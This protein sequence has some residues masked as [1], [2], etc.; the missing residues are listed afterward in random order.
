MRYSSTGS[1]RAYLEG[2]IARGKGRAA[3]RLPPARELARAAGVAESTLLK[4]VRQLRDEGVLEVSHGKGIRTVG[5]PARCGPRVPPAESSGRARWQQVA[6]A[7]YTR[8]VRGEWETIP[9][10]KELRGMLGASYP[11]LRRALDHLVRDGILETYKRTYRVA[12]PTVPS[13]ANMVVLISRGIDMQDMARAN[14]PHRDM[15]HELEYQCSRQQLKLRPVSYHYR[16][17]LLHGFEEL[18]KVVRSDWVLGYIICAEGIEHNCLNNTLR[19]LRDT[20]RPVALFTR[21]EWWD[22][23]ALVQPRLTRIYAPSLGPAPGRAVAHYLATL[24]HQRIAFVD[25][26]LANNWSRERLQGMREV[27]RLGGGAAAVTRFTP[28][29][30]VL[31]TT[32][33]GRL[34]REAERL[35]DEMVG[36]LQPSGDAQNWASHLLT[37]IPGAAGQIRV[38]IELRTAVSECLDRILDDPD[39][40]CIVGANDRMA[41][42]CLEG[43][44]ERGIDVPGRLSVAGFDNSMEAF[45]A[46][47]TSY[48]FGFVELFRRMLFFVLR[49]NSE[50]YYMGRSIVSRHLG[51]LVPRNTTAPRPSP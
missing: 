30:G 34:C 29:A 20:N 2:L 21:G 46:G 35:S 41:L 6:T 39:I 9:S 43:L 11:T 17:T 32:D 16:G 44:W 7:L 8:I 51:T 25:E 14:D 45:V 36:Q 13:R 31:P 18:R 19:L 38:R 23:S 49:P 33:L 4:A 12:S 24:G 26:L 15:V 37:R 3:R 28:V 1:A 42:A 22:F 48:D 40:T 50:R 47:L 10:L 27:L 5:G